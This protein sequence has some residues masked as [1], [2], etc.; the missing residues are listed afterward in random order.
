MIGELHKARAKSTNLGYDSKWKLFAGFASRAGFDPYGASPAQMAD[1]LTYLFRERKL[2]PAT[3]KSYRAAIGHVLR[4]ASGYDPGQDNIVA[5]LMKSFQRQRPFF[6]NTTP[7]WDVSLVLAAWS[8]THNNQMALDLLQTK[9][10]FLTALA[11]GARRSE[12][13]A[14]IG[15]AHEDESDP[16]LLVVQFSPDFVTKTQFSRGDKARFSSISLPA[17]PTHSESVCPAAAV[18]TFLRRT[19]SLRCSSNSA[20]FFNL[21]EPARPTT[22]QLISANV[23]RAVRWAYHSQR[24][25]P[26]PHIRAH[27]TRA[28]SSSL[29]VATGTGLDDILEA[30]KWT[31]PSMY[32]K[33][34]QRGISLNARADLKRFP[35]IACAGKVI[36]TSLL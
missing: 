2:K 30:G 14:L 7:S 13:W 28:I 35:H 24:Q 27:E 29:R 18:R 11:S 31:S 34:Y 5:L 12:L 33:H 10:I 4:L 21:S 23:V 1:F 9:A 3:I 25:A 36:D 32:F 8:T 16:S 22:K 6:R 17:L 15:A 19:E 26:P 20:L